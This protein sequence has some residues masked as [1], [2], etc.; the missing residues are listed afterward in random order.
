[1]DSVVETWRV[2]EDRPLAATPPEPSASGPAANSEVAPAEAHRWWIVLAAGIAMVV[3]AAVL[4][5]TSG[6][7]SGSLAINAAHEPVGLAGASK[8]APSASAKAGGVASAPSTLP[9][10]LIVEVNG[11]VPRPGVYRLADGSRIGDAVSAAGGFGA[12]V[13]ARAAQALNLA[14]RLTDGQQIH[15]P[16]RDERV[17]VAPGTGAAAGGAA[18]P[19]V[20]AP[21]TSGPVDLN[22][23]TSAQLEALPAIGPATAAKIIAGRPYETVDQLRERKVVGQATLDKIR[24]LVTVR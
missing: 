9:V 14:A 19:N 21:D 16:S 22:S 2:L 13:D 24:E 8:A 1:V 6:T 4:L 7:S 17:A 18:A 20:S 5:V 12:R 11:A 3:G 23:A 10:L 15:V